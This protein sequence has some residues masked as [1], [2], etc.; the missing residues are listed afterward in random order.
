MTETLKGDF[1]NFTQSTEDVRQISEQAAITN[2]FLCGFCPRKSRVCTLHAGDWCAPLR[3][4]CPHVAPHSPSLP[5]HLLTQGSPRRGQNRTGVK[6]RDR[7]AGEG[8]GS[9]SS[10]KEQSG[11]LGV[12][13]RALLT[14]QREAGS[15]RGARREGG[16]TACLGGSGSDVHRFISNSRPPDLH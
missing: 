8:Q 11:T 15:R 7:A 13:G 1:P 5:L 12:P 2:D 4:L 9:L 16:H 10:T 14:L 6:W 3:T